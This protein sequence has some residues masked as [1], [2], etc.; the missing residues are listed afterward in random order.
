[1]N[2]QNAIFA[3]ILVAALLGI[4]VSNSLMTTVLA[5][6]QPGVTT[7]LFCIN[8]PNGQSKTIVIPLQA[9]LVLE[10]QGIGFPRPCEST[11]R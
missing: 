11:I 4:T 2:K 5:Q 1:M 3:I 9:A 7:T 8:L 6:T 10:K